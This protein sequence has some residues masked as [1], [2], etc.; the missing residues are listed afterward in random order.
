MF[1]LSCVLAQLC[2]GSVV[3]CL[4]C[5]LSQLCFGSVVLWLSCALAQLWAQLLF[6]HLHAG[7]VDS[8]ERA[9]FIRQ[10]T[11]LRIF[12]AFAVATLCLWKLLLLNC[13]VHSIVVLC[14]VVFG[15][16]WGFGVHLHASEF[17]GK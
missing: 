12:F 6:A 3:F 15:S 14:C 13:V 9:G 2:F 11:F 10:S 7:V 8:K 1:W 5:V 16:I 4:S 17:C